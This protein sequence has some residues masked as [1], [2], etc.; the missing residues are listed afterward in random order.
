M[1]RK[2]VTAPVFGVKALPDEGPGVFEAIVSVFGN[3]D[4]VNDRV[5][6]G[7]FEKSLAEWKASGDP[8]PTIFSH[9]WDDLDAHIGEVLEAKELLPGDVL[10][11]SELAEL[12]GLWTKFRLDVEEPEEVSSRKVARLLESRRIKEFS[13]AYDV[14]DHRRGTDGANEL[15]ELGLIEVGPTLKG[16]NPL[17]VSLAKSLD[18]E[19]DLLAERKAYVEVDFAGAIESEL[20]AVKDAATTW[21]RGNDIG[22]GGFYWLYLEATYPDEKR[23]VVLVEGWD[24]PCGDGIFFEL[25]YTID[26]E[27]KA[28]V[29]EPAEIEVTVTTT[30]KSAELR[31]RQ[32]PGSFLDA[33]TG[34]TLPE[35]SRG[36]KSDGN[37]EDPEGGNGED[38]KTE[39]EGDPITAGSDP[40]LVDLELLEAGLLS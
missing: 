27:G 32:G 28:T 19:L 37:P 22:N 17:T 21:A 26:A 8:I 13:F 36:T 16:A 1:N 3:V 35:K 7:A 24:D 9:R 29:S 10:L 6:P 30:L 34:A 14:I 5:I 23:A 11:P 20:D 38:S 31:H 39:T 40:L 33:K 25:A 2:H 12:G 4:L 15:V 18:Q